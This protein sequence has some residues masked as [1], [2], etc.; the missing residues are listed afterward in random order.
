[1]S[2]ELGSINIL[3]PS[4]SVML[5]GSKTVLAYQQTS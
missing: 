1:V 3:N 5:S 2:W 4:N